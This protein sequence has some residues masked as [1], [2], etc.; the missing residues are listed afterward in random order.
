MSKLVLL[1]DSSVSQS[2]DAIVNAA[3]KNLLGGSGVCGA[4]FKLAGFEKLTEYCSKIKTPLE[5]GEAVITPSFS[6]PN[7]D[8]IIHA[9]GPNFNV[10]P[11]A[12]DTLTKA[13]YNS[14][15]VLKDNELHSISF[16][17]IS[18]GIFGGKLPNPVSISTTKCIE[19]YNLFKEE[20]PDYD[21][22]VLLCAFT[23]KEYLEA[24]EVY[25]ELYSEQVLKK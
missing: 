15:Q 11:D 8:Y 5:D 3:N 25:N 19:A 7:C 2:V 13:Y 14:L 22:D 18:S 10:T 16:P 17:L 4:I 23:E 21:I 24:I 9:V 12:F 1:N 20:N 6:I